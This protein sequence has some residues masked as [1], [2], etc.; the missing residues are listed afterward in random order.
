MITYIIGSA[1]LRSLVF[2]TRTGSIAGEIKE[3]T[4]SR[5]IIQPISPFLFWGAR[6][7]ADKII[8][9]GFALLEITAVILI[10][11][12][13]IYIPKN[14]INVVL[15][16]LV[17]TSAILL[18]YFISLSLSFAA[19]WT[20]EVWATRWLF[21]YIFLEF[22]SGAIF[23]IDILPDVLQKIISYTPFPLLMFFPL[24]I[25]LEQTSPQEILKGFAL[26]I[27][28]TVIAYL[29][30]R[31]LWKKGSKNYGAYGG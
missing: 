7:I 24:K 4:L 9:I 5:L 21:G 28:W 30:A 31:Y 8:N 16:L 6:D 18:Y 20:Q 3:G 2:G 23:P 12:L 22:F 19:F 25:L 26:I 17:S 11:D 15:F 29:L 10:L 27:F 14:P 13:T 1:L